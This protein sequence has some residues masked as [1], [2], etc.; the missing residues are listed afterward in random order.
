MAEKTVQYRVG[1]AESP[2][3]GYNP[4]YDIDEANKQEV[5]TSLDKEEYN[6]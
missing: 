3:S 1:G 2:E 6:I 5:S 4:E